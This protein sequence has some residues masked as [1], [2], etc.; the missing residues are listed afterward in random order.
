[1]LR[2]LS[3]G[4]QQTITDKVLEQE[5]HRQYRELVSGRTR[6]KVSD[7]RKL[8]EATVITTEKVL[9]LR[10]QRER[11]EAIKELKRAK[12]S[13]KVK[14]L[15]NSKTVAK[16]GPSKPIKKAKIAKM[17]TVYGLSSSNELQSWEEPAEEWGEGVGSDCDQES[18]SSESVE[19]L[20][21]PGNSIFRGT[22]K[23][24]NLLADMEDGVR[25]SGRAL[26]PRRWN[27][28]DV[29]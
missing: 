14:N 7:R 26:K 13:S 1:V 6:G 17:V 28:K 8:T 4:F 20:L 11:Q 2:G 19:D 5:S 15:E 10:E 29:K 16:G 27:I 22:R 9:Q 18:T 25:R 24:S 21:E 3:E 23:T 12:K